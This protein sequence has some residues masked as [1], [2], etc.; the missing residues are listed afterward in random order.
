MNLLKDIPAGDPNDLLNVVVEIPMGSSIKYEYSHK[1]QMMVADR[2]LYT[3][4]TYPFNYGFIPGTWSEDNDPMDIVVLASQPV[5]TGTVIECRV[6]GV[7]ETEDEEGGDAKV[8]AVP[9]AKVDPAFAHV[10]NI[11]DLPEYLKNKI[12]HFYEN[13]KSIEPNKWVKVTGWQGREEAIKQVGECVERFQKS[14]SS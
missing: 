1:L 13:Y 9:K 11:D 5:T 10:N 2:F 12:K 8:I 3:A 6:I 14:S 4:F 7:L